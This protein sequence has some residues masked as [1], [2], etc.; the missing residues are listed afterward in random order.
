MAKRG[1]KTKLT[2][3]VQEAIVAAIRSGNYAC[4]ACEYGGITTQTYYRWLRQGEEAKSGRYRNFYLAIKKAEADAEVRIVAYWQKQIPEN[5]QAARD[6]L[7][8]RFPERWRK[9]YTQEVTGKDG[10]PV[11]VTEVKRELL[12]K[13]NRLIDGRQQGGQ[14]DPEPP[15][16]GTSQ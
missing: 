4:V 9:Q 16:F 10:G 1:P 5:W 15:T 3:E 2:P 14:D 6:F 8:R 13:V 12:D 11:E 7:E